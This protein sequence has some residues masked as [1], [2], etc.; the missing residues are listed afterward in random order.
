MGWWTR[1]EQI[2]K[3]LLLDGSTSCLDFVAMINIA[4]G[5]WGTLV[6]EQICMQDFVLI[7]D[8]VS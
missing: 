8:R 2:I 3:L 4:I 1:N 5:D 6:Y 7:L